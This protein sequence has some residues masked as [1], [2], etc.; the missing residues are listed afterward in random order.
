MI[1]INHLN[2]EITGHTSVRV[3]RIHCHQCGA[4]EILKASGDVEVFEEARRKH[5]DCLAS[6]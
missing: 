1:E 3:Y 4:Q 6:V 2:T 5:A